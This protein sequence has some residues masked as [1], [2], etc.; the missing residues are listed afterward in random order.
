M[1]I[2]TVGERG[3]Q[4]RLEAKYGYFGEE[5][6]KTGRELAKTLGRGETVTFF[7]KKK[8]KRGVNHN[9]ARK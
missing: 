1:E 7:K 4:A 3:L 5:C 8:K 6:V 2:P 9:R